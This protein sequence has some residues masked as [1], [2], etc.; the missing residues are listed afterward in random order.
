MFPPT[1]KISAGCGPVCTAFPRFHFHLH[2]PPAKLNL[3]GPRFPFLPGRQCAG[4][5]CER[6]RPSTA[7]TGCRDA[8]QPELIAQGQ[9]QRKAPTVVRLVVQGNQYSAPI[10]CRDHARAKQLLFFKLVNLNSAQDYSCFL[11]R[12]VGFDANDVSESRSTPSSAFVAR[13]QNCARSGRSHVGAVY[14]RVHGAVTLK[15]TKR[16]VP[17]TGDEH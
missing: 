16:N 3:P 13:G 17:C 7:C 6:K 12:S 9:D 10:R 5:A 2:K 15:Q 4:D 1:P 11:F 8:N 14:V